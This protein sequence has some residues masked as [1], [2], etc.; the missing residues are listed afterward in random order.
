MSNFQYRK[1]NSVCKTQTAVFSFTTI[2]IIA[3]V[4]QAAFASAC[5]SQHLAIYKAPEQLELAN[6]K[7]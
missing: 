4:H 6:P 2:Q 1:R 3:D 7:T 5:P